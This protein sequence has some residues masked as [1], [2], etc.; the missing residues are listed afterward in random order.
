M[1]MKALIGYED[2]I[3][4]TRSRRPRENNSHVK[5]AGALP[6]RLWSCGG[7]RSR[8]PRGSYAAATYVDDSSVHAP[9]SGHFHHVG[10]G[11]Q[12]VNLP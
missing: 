10:R 5:V 6:T 9:L 3:Q 2:V 8:Y 1:A 11:V 4:S 7:G 12:S